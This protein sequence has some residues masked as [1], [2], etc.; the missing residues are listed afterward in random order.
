MIIKIDNSIS[1][2]IQK[3]HQGNFHCPQV[4]IMIVGDAGVAGGF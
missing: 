4:V 2:L 3:R 1:N